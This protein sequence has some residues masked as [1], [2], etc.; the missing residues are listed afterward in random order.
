MNCNHLTLHTGFA[1]FLA[2]SFGFSLLFCTSIKATLREQNDSLNQH[3][4]QS[5]VFHL[6]QEALRSLMWDPTREPAAQSCRVRQWLLGPG[7]VR[8]LIL[9]AA[10]MLQ[11]FHYAHARISIAPEMLDP[12]K[13]INSTQEQ[14]WPGGPL[15]DKHMIVSGMLNGHTHACRPLSVCRGGG[16]LEIDLPRFKN[17][18]E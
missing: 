10:G 15:V 9:D 4:T 17:N 18:Q 16:K 3:L 5:G 13:A 12:E 11:R 7:N 6:L 1:F 14:Q 2:E 8:M